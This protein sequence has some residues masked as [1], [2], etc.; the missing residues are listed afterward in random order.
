MKCVYRS[1]V[2][3][4]SPYRLMAEHRKEQ[5]LRLYHKLPTLRTSP[6]NC[7][8]RCNGLDTTCPEY[9]TKHYSIS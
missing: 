4:E 3:D 8:L 5:D 9:H 6:Y 7:I 2:E 1:L